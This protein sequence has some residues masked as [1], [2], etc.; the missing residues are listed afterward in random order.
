MA[1]GAENKRPCLK[2]GGREGD[3]QG[4]HTGMEE[5]DGFFE[6]KKKT[7]ILSIFHF[8]ISQGKNKRNK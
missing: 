4:L 7:T 2:Q 5:E 8:L 6:R 1:C 3:S